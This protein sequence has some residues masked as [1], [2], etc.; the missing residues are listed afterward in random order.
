MTVEGG[1]KR[2]LSA[3]TLQS[4]ADL[5]YSVD[6]SQADAYTLS[7]PRAAKSVADR[8]QQPFCD[9]SGLPEP[10]YVSEIE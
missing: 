4:L 1:D 10:V 8:D 9:V 3:I 6:L 2:V 5:G 7:A